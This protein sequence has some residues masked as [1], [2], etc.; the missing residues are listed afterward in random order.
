MVDV[1]VAYGYSVSRPDA[2]GLCAQVQVPLLPLR[3]IVFAV[4]SWTQT[5]LLENPEGG[6]ADAENVIP[7]L[8]GLFPKAKEGPGFITT[9]PVVVVMLG[10]VGPA[11]LKVAWAVVVWLLF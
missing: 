9:W 5:K 3:V 11:M 2:F 1:P 6:F 8:G 7:M 10:E 4:I